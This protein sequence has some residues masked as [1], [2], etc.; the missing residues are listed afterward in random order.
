V[1]RGPA[2][3][4][5]KSRGRTPNTTTNDTTNDATN[6]TTNGTTNTTTN[7]TT[8]DA[9]N[10]TTNDA[11]DP[12]R[13]A[14][15][16][17]DQPLLAPKESSRDRR[18][19]SQLMLSQTAIL[20]AAETIRTLLP[21]GAAQKHVARYLSYEHAG[22]DR[23]LLRIERDK[24]FDGVDFP[25]WLRRGTIAEAICCLGLGSMRNALAL[26]ET[27]RAQLRRICRRRREIESGCT[28]DDA[29]CEFDEESLY[30]GPIAASAD[31]KSKR[32]HEQMALE[33]R[34]YLAKLATQAR[35]LYG[36][37]LEEA[38]AY[39]WLEWKKRALTSIGASQ[40]LQLE[41]AQLL[42]ASVCA[43]VWT[44]THAHVLRVA[45]YEVDEE[46]DRSN[47]EKRLSLA[48]RADTNGAAADSFSPELN[49]CTELPLDWEPNLAVPINQFSE[50]CS[51]GAFS[52]QIP[53]GICSKGVNIMQQLLARSINP[54]SRGW[55]SSLQTAMKKDLSVQTVVKDAFMVCL[56]GLHGAIEPTHRPRWH[57]R[58]QIQTLVRP[59]MEQA[60]LQETKAL[61][62]VIK[63]VMRR[64]LAYNL[65]HDM[66]V[67]AAM[68]SLHMQAAQL[69]HPPEAMPSSGLLEGMRNIAKLSLAMVDIFY[70]ANQPN[71][72]KRPNDPNEPH[73]DAKLAK[74][75][76]YV[77]YVAEFSR[78]CRNTA[79][80]TWVGRVKPQPP[81]LL[82]VDECGELLMAGFEARFV[83]FWIHSV[84]RGARAQRLDK[85][86]YDGIHRHNLVLE[87]ANA[88]DESHTLAIQRRVLRHKSGALLTLQEALSMVLPLVDDLL[89]E[90]ER[91]IVRRLCQSNNPSDRDNDDHEGND[92][93]QQCLE[94][95]EA[96]S[97]RQQTLVETLPAVVLAGLLHFGSTAWLCEQTKVVELGPRARILHI[98]VLANVQHLLSKDDRPLV[99]DLMQNWNDTP[100]IHAL[101]PKVDALERRLRQRPMQLW[102]ICA[103]MECRR[104]A[105]AMHQS[106]P[107][108]VQKRASSNAKPTDS[109]PKVGS[110]Y[111]V[112]IVAAMNDADDR[113]HLYCAKRPSAALKTALLSVGNAT[114]MAVD[115]DEHDPRPHD[116]NGNEVHQSL[117]D[118]FDDS[119]GTNLDDNMEDADA[120]LGVVDGELENGSTVQSSH[121]RMRRDTKRCYEQ[122]RIAETCG[123]HAMLTIDCIG[124]VV[125]LMD[126]WYTICTFC[127]VIMR[128][129]PGAQIGCHLA[130]STCHSLPQKAAQQPYASADDAILSSILDDLANETEQ[131]NVQ[132]SV[133]V[134]TASCLRERESDKTC[135][136]CNSLC[137][138]RGRGFV[139]YHSPHDRRGVNEVRP[140]A[141]RITRWCP[142]HNRAWLKD[143]LQIMPTNIVL[144]HIMMH[145]KPVNL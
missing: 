24:L 126:H 134:R 64:T 23:W 3:G 28:A 122:R 70:T 82:A 86:Q 129:T 79:V 12:M 52:S 49:L 95:F 16:T 45:N 34:N 97:T 67:R 98:L 30:H 116:D 43:A 9:T 132:L 78:L 71:R 99:R 102:S 26:F 63:D 73:L 96:T 22:I 81:R 74:S 131:N 18:T 50:T 135:R 111:E 103:C 92:N 58:C 55:S 123:T 10:G 6:G 47:A 143:A 46:H 37:L 108:M 62:E 141:L 19:P 100:K 105:N 145:A 120:P 119:L 5:L 85:D 90:E 44:S 11:N 25:S 88:L 125:Q 104:V 40:A 139:A 59:V 1:R 144:A 94:V 33:P 138:R 112:G 38:V 48:C 61:A 93:D 31:S 109:R 36:A 20:D 17:T 136:Y 7:T 133:G 66:A 142:K 32:L 60:V 56:N 140:S 35:V 65:H 107:K 14:V 117:D 121:S 128:C 89:C 106:D 83:P 21:I 77:D 127:G 113:D 84:R 69:I 54:A 75:C 15:A 110:F 124:R 51:S 42:H 87:M 130:C 13:D 57:R 76:D 53:L 2:H 101:A 29:S 4:G 118:A 115:R 91:T 68:A 114:R 39:L 41:G 137:V 27:L 8:N 80:S 72:P